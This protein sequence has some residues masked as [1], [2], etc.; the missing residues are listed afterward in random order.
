VNLTCTEPTPHISIRAQDGNTGANCRGPAGSHCACGP[1]C[2]PLPPESGC[3]G[4]NDNFAIDTAMEFRVAY[5]QP[6]QPRDVTA[7]WVP[8][9]SPVTDGQYAYLRYLLEA[10]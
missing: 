2:S 7:I 10:P 6:V 1:F 9:G 4:D 5:E 3:F 8:Q